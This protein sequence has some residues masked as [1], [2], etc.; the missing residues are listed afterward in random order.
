MKN[1]RIPITSYVV[2]EAESPE[3]ARSLFL[4]E[5]NKEPDKHN[6]YDIS[7]DLLLNAEVEG[8]ITEEEPYD[9]DDDSAD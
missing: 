7:D 5:V 6:D 1:W 9:A 4:N 3:I 8:D 2:I